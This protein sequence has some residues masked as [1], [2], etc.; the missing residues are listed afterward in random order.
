[1]GREQKRA[2]KREAEKRERETQLAANRPSTKTPERGAV[3]GI[4]EAEDAAARRVY[5]TAGGSED[6]AKPARHLVEKPRKW[7]EGRL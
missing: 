7:R 6:R 3:G 2:A 5:R 4:L 1:M